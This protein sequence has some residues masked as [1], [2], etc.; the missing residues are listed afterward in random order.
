MN[1]SLSRFASLSPDL[2][3]A[4]A[5]PFPVQQVELR[6]GTHEQRS[7]HWVC[8]AVPFVPKRF[9]EDR[10]N[11]L[12]PGK[13]R[14]ITPFTRETAGH[15]VIAAQVEILGV[16]HTDYSERPLRPFVVQREQEVGVPDAHAAFEYAF[17]GACAVFGM[18]RYLA[19]LERRWVPYDPRHRCMNLSP[20]DQLELVLTLYREAN[21]PLT[22]PRTGRLQPSYPGWPPLEQ[23]RSRREKAKERQVD[24]IVARMRARDLQWLRGCC[25]HAALQRIYQHFGVARLEELTDR[26]LHGVIRGVH[27][28]AALKKNA[29]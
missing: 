9:Y 10:L 23:G 4:L 25:D 1:T 2:L 14:S 3:A 22:F 12:V 13:W 29:A 26:Q 28:H 15:L 24:E 7:P 5:Q 19:D 16:A 17:V 11:T 27:A 20:S 6:V 8:Q 21:I 18:G